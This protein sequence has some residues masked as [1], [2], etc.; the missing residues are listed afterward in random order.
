MQAPVAEVDIE[1][2]D[3]AIAAES[4]ASD[5]N[6]PKWDNNWVFNDGHWTHLQPIHRII[7]WEGY[8]FQ[9]KAR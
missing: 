7:T 2:G 8:P 3:N 4:I 5:H 6:E 9:S 1:V